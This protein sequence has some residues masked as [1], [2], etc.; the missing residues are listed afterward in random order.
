MDRYLTPA[1]VSAR[2]SGQ[3]KVKTLSNWRS[4]D[5]V[6]PDFLK[7]GGRILYRL[8]AVIAWEREREFR[9]TRD[10]GR[11]PPSPGAAAPPAEK[12]R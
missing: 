3:I 1:E 2:Y 11:N 12:I 4:L 7:A 10:Y 6:G 9:S 5:D 8:S